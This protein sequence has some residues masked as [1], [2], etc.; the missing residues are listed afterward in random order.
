MRIIQRNGS[1]AIKEPMDLGKAVGEVKGDRELPVHCPFAG[2]FGRG[3]M[4]CMA[5]GMLR[6]RYNSGIRVVYVG[7]TYAWCKLHHTL[8]DQHTPSRNHFTRVR[9][10][11]RLPAKPSLRYHHEPGNEGSDVNL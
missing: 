6:V 7:V 9:R 11:S 1:N 2:K 5:V 8:H 10:Q 4:F 3:G